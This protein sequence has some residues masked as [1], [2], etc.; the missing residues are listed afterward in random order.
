MKITQ[1]IENLLRKKKADSAAATVP[2]VKLGSAI[3]LTGD[4][5]AGDTPDGSGL[6]DYDKKYASS[7]S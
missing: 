7:S 2:F 5:E 1:A 6:K 3:Q 4:S